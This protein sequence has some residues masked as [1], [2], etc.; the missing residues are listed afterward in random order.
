MFVALERLLHLHEG[1]RRT[2]RIAGRN[3]LLLI[4]DNN[5]VLLENRCPYQGRN[6]RMKNQ[7]GWMLR[8][9]RHGIE[10]DLSCGRA[11]NGNCPGLT[12]FRLCHDGDRIGIDLRAFRQR[13]GG[14]HLPCCNFPE[15]FCH[16]IC[17]PRSVR[18]LS[19][20]G[21]GGRADVQQ[22]RWS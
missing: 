18:R 4:V 15:E 11:L 8:C 10:F 6:C 20:T 14:A 19:R 7:S 3:L 9:R 2:F 21:T 22:L 13:P 16:A 1:Y 12:L 5:A 17:H